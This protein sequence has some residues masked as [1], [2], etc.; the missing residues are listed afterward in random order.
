M[1]VVFITIAYE[2]EAYNLRTSSAIMNLNKKVDWVL[3]DIIVDP[4]I[5]F[6]VLFHYQ[7]CMPHK[8]P[9]STTLLFVCRSSR[10]WHVRDNYNTGNTVRKRHPYSTPRHA[11]RKRPRKGEPSPFNT[12]WYDVRNTRRAVPIIVRVCRRTHTQVFRLHAH[13]TICCCFRRSRQSSSY[14]PLV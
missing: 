8:V 3:F 4:Y 9:M 14:A 10:N 1:V 11:V 13:I 12:W 5:L 2:Y 7:F 6:D